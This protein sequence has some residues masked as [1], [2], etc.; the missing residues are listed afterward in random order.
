[1][2]HWLIA[3]I[4]GLLGLVTGWVIVFYF[5]MYLGDKK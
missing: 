1:M 3:V 5:M 2:K 4:F